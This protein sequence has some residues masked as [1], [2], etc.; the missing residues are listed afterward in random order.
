MNVGPELLLVTAVAAVGVLHTIVPDH[1]MPIALIARQR[2][3][4]KAE[5]VRASL[6]AG[7]GHVVSTLIIAVIVWS[8]G[9]A[10]AERFGRLVDTA[11]SLALVG[12]GAWIAISSWREL[13]L[14]GGH[15]HSHAFPHLHRHER[16]DRRRSIHGPELRHVITPEGVLQ[17][18]IFEAGVPPRF[19][20]SGVPAE[21]V[22]LQT[23]RD[24]GKRQ[25]F[26][27]AKLG[28]YWESIDE[29]PEPH[30]FAVTIVVCHDEHQHSYEARFTEHDHAHDGHG[31]DHDH[32]GEYELAS[33]LE[34]DPLYAPLRG[35][36]AVLTRH[37]HVHR[38]GQGAVHEHWHDHTPAA[39]HLVTAAL[40]TTPPEHD[41]RH[42]TTARTAL[43]LILGSSPMIEG[44]PAFFAAGKYGV[45]LITIMTIVFAI[46]T[47]AT[48][49]VLCVYSTAGL[50]RARLGAF[51]RY[52][53]VLSGAFIAVVGLAFW[54]WPT[55]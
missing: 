37:K 52:G 34:K 28:N 14:Q 29:I 47:I 21:S 24:N 31:H 8:A 55:L 15:G 10:V 3:W 48:Y 4:S 42:K 41:H 49:V 9:V 43:L 30:Q 26:P 40:K 36:I 2:G 7:I 18:S 35:E 38:H 27:F 16:G 22:S 20:L 44:I 23:H 50:Q 6:Q 11:S 19:R 54:L 53:E 39:S 5:T 32:G 25:D 51:E 13:R 45:G 12:F 33:D 17:L 46:S 1:W